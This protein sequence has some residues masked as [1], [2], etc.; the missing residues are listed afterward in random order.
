MSKI[1]NKINSKYTAL[2]II[3]IGIIYRFWFF[4]IPSFGGDESEHVTKAIRVARGL[5]DVIT[6]K[7][8]NIALANI[9]QPIL[10][11]NHP[12]LEF[13][14]LVPSVFIQP[15][16]FSARLIY[17]LAGIATM[18]LAYKILKN[19]RGYKV[20]I[21]FLA[22]FATSYY[23]IS[24]TQIVTFGL[25]LIAAVFITLAVMYFTKSP[26]ANSLRWLVLT[27]AFGLWIS[28]DYL[29]FIPPI[30]VIIWLN[31][32]TLRKKD[33]LIYG[34]TFIIL[35]SLFYLP[36]YLYSRTPSS[37]KAAGFNYYLN[38]YLKSASLNQPPDYS[39]GQWLSFMWF[40]FF[41]LPSIILIWPF[42]L[43]GLTCI[44]KHKYLGYLTLII[45]TVILVEFPFIKCCTNYLNIFGILLILAVE[46]I[47]S[48][49]TIGI[50]IG[51]LMVV[52]NI[53]ITSVYA[54]N[55]YN[56]LTKKG[57]Y[58]KDNIKKLA[59]TAKN[60]L[61]DNKTYISTGD[62]WRTRYYFGKNMLPALEAEEITD[63]R[64]TSDFLENKLPY[65]IAFI[66]IDRDTISNSLEKKV[67]EKAV[68]EIITTKD[69][70]YLFDECKSQ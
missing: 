28:I 45:I 6:L 55:N 7:N 12:P 46:G 51:L 57:H 40:Y 29:I 2:G 17:V 60:C 35:V 11:H 49:K 4:W 58:T 53:V 43:L 56:P 15:R 62:A 47:L 39:L 69:K 36:Y 66:H 37:P 27:T 38:A 61:T 54:L 63:E 10:Q 23:V 9:Y 26:A 48:I 24:Y 22:L 59:Q 20:G 41:G 44:K 1:I 42:S 21:I 34:I 30:I 19:I 65:E 32:N 14:I 50:G 33:L 68:K 25:N 8:I 5:L 64:A 31:R 18:L 16:E 52:A 67:S 70:L 13:L 3:L